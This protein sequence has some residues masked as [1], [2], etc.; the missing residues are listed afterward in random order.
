MGRWLAAPPTGAAPFERSIL[1]FFFRLLIAELIA[2]LELSEK[3]YRLSQRLALDQVP[4]DVP[5][6]YVEGRST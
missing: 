5:F 2:M 4:A 6:L 3:A 1:L